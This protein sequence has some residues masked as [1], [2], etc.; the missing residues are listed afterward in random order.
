M[1]MGVAMA[2]GAG[3]AYADDADTGSPAASGSTSTRSS[4]SDTADRNS[5]SSTPTNRDPDDEASSD[6]APADDDSTQSISGESI[7]DEDATATSGGVADGE[8]QNVESADI[9]DND[10]FG[11]EE[12]ESSTVP[13]EAESA[14]GQGV[15]PA[16]SSG[17]GAGETDLS[18]TAALRDRPTALAESAA[19]GAPS[20]ATE[21]IIDTASGRSQPAEIS[22][23][24]IADL[25]PSKAAESSELAA[26][27]ALARG[28]SITADI[29]TAAALV[30]APV[31]LGSIVNDV[32]TWTGLGPWT[33]HLPIPALP[34]PA[35]VEALWLAVRQ[36]M[37]TWNNQRPVATTI[38]SGQ[39]PLTGIITGRIDTVDY[40]G[41]PITYI[42]STDAAHGEVVIDADGTFTYTPDPEYALTGGPDRF[43]VTVEDRIGNPP[44]TYGLLGA[45]GLVGPTTTA[46]SLLVLPVLPLNRSP[47]PGSPPFSYSVDTA[48]GVVSGTVNVSDPDGDELDFLLDTTIDPAQGSL[49]VDRETGDWTYTPTQDARETAYTTPG[50]DAALFTVTVSDGAA[51]ITVNVSAPITELV[52]APVNQAP[53]AG[54]PA[55]GYTV[56]TDTG[57]ITGTINVTDPD[58]DDLEYSVNLMDPARGTVVVNPDTGGWTY[59]PSTQAQFEAWKSPGADTAAFSIVASD[60]KATVAVEIS[61]PITPAADFDVVAVHNAGDVVFHVVTT[62]DGRIVVSNYSQGALTVIR[63]DGSTDTIDIDASFPYGLA[64]GPDGK[65]YV[66][67]YAGG[68]VS[69]VDL[70]NNSSTV[71]ANVPGPSAIA[72]DGDGRIYVG[73][74]DLSSGIKLGITVV[75]PDGS[76]VT[77]I[78]TTGVVTGLAA[79]PDGRVY[80]GV[81][82]YSDERGRMLVLNPDGSIDTVLSEDSIPYAVAAGPDGRVYVTELSTTGARITILNPD[83][84]T[85]QIPLGSAMPVGID[86]DAQGRIYV[87]N[88]IDSTVTVI[89]PRP[90]FDNGPVVG[91]PSIVVDNVDTETGAVTGYFNVV[92]PEGRP[93]SYILDTTVSAEVGSLVVDG[94]TGFWTFTPT[95]AARET[96]YDTAG[97]DSLSFAVTIS[98]DRTAVMVN[99]SAPITE[100]APPP[101]YQAPVVNEEEPYTLTPGEPDPS[102]GAITGQVNVTDD[103]V[104][105]YYVVTAPDPALGALELDEQTG[106]WTFTPHPRTRVL[107]SSLEQTQQAAMTVSFSVAATDGT[108]AT[109]AIVV[110]EHVAG[111]P[112][113]AV[114]L[115]SGQLPVQS[116]IDPVTGDGY[117]F[118]YNEEQQATSLA[119]VVHP[120]GSYSITSGPSVTGLLLHTV[121]VGDT[122][123]AVAIGIE[124][125]QTYV[126]RLGPD[127]LTP[128]SG[129]IAGRP[130]DPSG[131]TLLRIAAG[132]TTYIVTHSYD[133]DSAQ[134]H[135]TGLGQAGVTSTTSIPGWFKDFIVVGDSTFVVTEAGDYD[136]GYETRVIEVGP[137]GVTPTVV[138]MPGK[139]LGEPIV[140]GD[141]TYVLTAN[142]SHFMTHVMALTPE[143]AIPVGSIAGGVVGNPLVVGGNAYLLSVT[144]R[145]DSA[146]FRQIYVTTLTPTPAGVTLVGDPVSGYLPVSAWGWSDNPGVVVGDTTYVVVQVNDPSSGFQTRLI[147]VGPDGL[148]PVGAG[149]PGHPGTPDPVIVVAG[150]T[151]YLVTS[152]YNSST[153]YQTQLLAVGPDGLTPVG[154]PVNHPGVDHIADVRAVVAGD[155]TYLAMWTIGPST[156][157][158]THLLA[159]GPD[160]LTWAGAPAPGRLENY[161]I[162]AAIV[163]D[164]AYLVTVTG[165]DDSGYQTHLTAVTPDDVVPVDVVIPGRVIQ[166]AGVPFPRSIVVGDT[167]YLVTVTDDSLDVNQFYLTA[168]GPEGVIPPGAPLS[169]RPEDEPVVVGDTTYMM[170]VTRRLNDEGWY[171][172]AQTHITVFTPG[173]DTPFMQYPF[174]GA[175][176]GD[177]I[178]VGDFTYLVSYTHDEQSGEYQSR[179]WEL[180]ADGPSPVGPPFP[181]APEGLGPGV[182]VIGDTTYVM[183]IGGLWGL[184]P[185]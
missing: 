88:Q 140:I 147:A 74:T 27:A 103:E 65:L 25:T 77:T 104:L 53:V 34:V 102:T 38:I 6:D 59:T 78:S 72:V 12:L 111:S 51:E 42:V 139:A 8:A 157:T 184:A 15:P 181:G 122:T 99:A 90:V 142:D 164:T 87:T 68:T 179:I 86:V 28:V 47:K 151:T 94:A 126:A 97:A 173:E 22:A 169:G 17:A 114:A 66:A 19:T 170:S 185:M 75:N 113:A 167:A 1:G 30:K 81:A 80:A 101:A 118:A 3:V 10:T 129:H 175:L 35:F 108:T 93:L 36:T 163:G 54:W 162:D 133:T 120:D 161:D 182:I 92:D 148:T 177:P 57:V 5:A 183:T 49:M 58:G 23:E 160:G 9:D 180:S 128:V 84:S 106:A 67:D 149:V 44:H 2:N 95:Q 52:P 7:D 115:P 153:G 110:S 37:Q 172:S 141:T 70:E 165:D 43:V 50:S 46:L 168:V 134:I 105:T 76:I 29:P 85:Q 48:T 174:E 152:T 171:E 4:D 98:D 107:A 156:G 137:D 45:L 132:D 125:Q 155:T 41:D 64:T 26:P 31:T 79:A 127:G 130:I 144:N 136:S 82:P 11:I 119:A 63:P 13:D 14:E 146:E 123:Y 159:V 117:I 16:G 39:D 143:G 69:V 166:I 91:V 55:Y 89:E 121:T 40:E 73:S 124:D 145:F 158:Q 83:G 61:A 18:T 131:T 109:A 33:A 150:D 21:P 100:L 154:E 112:I 135:L 20:E 71:V 62:G 138:P 178:I 24:P 96:A 32:L 176:H 60:D 116:F 56:N